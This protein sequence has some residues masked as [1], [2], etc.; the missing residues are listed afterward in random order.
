MRHVQKALVKIVELFA[1]CTTTT[2]WNNTQMNTYNAIVHNQMR[3][4][5]IGSV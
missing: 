3:E 2:V 4:V 5:P 1:T